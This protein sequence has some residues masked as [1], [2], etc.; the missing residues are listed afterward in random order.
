M[1]SKPP[2]VPP[3]NPAADASIGMA[4][5]GYC[6]PATRRSLAELRA[7]GLLTGSAETLAS[8]GFAY[9]HVANGETNLEMAADAARRVLRESATDPS[10][11]GLLLY[12]TALTGSATMAGASDRDS[13][14][15][16]D[17]VAESFQY[18]ASCLQAELELTRAT[19]AGVD[20]QGCASLL[21][22]LRIGRAM[23]VAEPA[24]GAVLC[25]SADVFPARA[26]R[27]LVYNVIS[28]GA[29]AV[30][31]KH[32][33]PNRILSC[34]QVTKGSY[35]DAAALEHEVIAAYF[36]TAKNL[37]M[38]ALSIAGLEL[39]DI[40]LVIPHN[41]SRRSWDILCG[42]LKLPADRVYTDN[43]ARVGHTIAA[44]N[45]LNLRDAIDSGRV[46]RG[47][48]LLLFTFGFGLNWSCIVVQH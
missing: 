11:I 21:S 44:D 45:I 16:L 36:P 47:D 39:D 38:E 6:L 46:A 15:R 28:D 20:Q 40:S 5:L 1:E 17:S 34:A 26:P 24:L 3:R 31:L 2:K 7:D 27:D 8:F 10:E 18:P 23:L 13:V 32:G 41:V 35:W 19:V 4:A 14:L 25:V 22:A 48:K 43:I 33:A 12:A 29:C 42:L 9:A 37:I 30:L